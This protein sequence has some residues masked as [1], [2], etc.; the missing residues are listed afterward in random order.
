M[1]LAAVTSLDE[2]RIAVRAAAPGAVLGRSYGME[3]FLLDG[4]PLLGMRAASKHLSVFPFSPE[5]VAAVAERLPGFALSKGTVR[6]SPSQPL[7]ADVLAEM[8]RLRAAEIR[9]ET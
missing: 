6:F 4:R 5:V 7:P 8:V 1:G 3:A 9:S 2:V